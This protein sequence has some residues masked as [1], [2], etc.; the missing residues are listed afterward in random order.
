MLS[1]RTVSLG[2]LAALCNR[3]IPATAANTSS[4]KGVTVLNVVSS[5]KNWYYASWDEG[6]RSFARSVG[7]AYEVIEHEGKLDICLQRIR[8]MIDKTRGN[9]VLNLD[10]ASKFDCRPFAELCHH[11]RIF[12]VTHSFQK[13]S[14]RPQEWNPYYVSHM[15]SNHKLAGFQTAKA[16]AA[17][18]GGRGSILALGG[19]LADLPAD[20]RKAGLDQLLAITRGCTLLD[21]QPADWEASVAFEITRLWLARYRGQANGIWAANDRMALGAIEALR[22]YRMIGTISVTGIDGFPDAISSVRNSELSATVPWD[23]FYEG[24]MGSA[25]AFSAKQHFVSPTLEPDEHREFYVT[26]DILTKDNVEQYLQ[27]RHIEN[28][29]VNWKD[30]WGRVNGQP[31]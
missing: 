11:S 31:A 30:L 14:A 2:S 1:R 13:T 8:T 12:F 9:M 4:A 16:L 3:T 29:T 19:P 6:G 28:S 5:L 24:G 17:A 27:Y 21:Y 15:V 26:L 22:I 18:M 20:Q 23:A 10:L 25:I 7:A